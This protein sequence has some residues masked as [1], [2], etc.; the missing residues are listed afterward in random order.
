MT[1]AALNGVL[2]AAREAAENT[3][4][5]GNRFERL[6]AL[7]LVSH[8]GVSGSQRFSHVWLWDD[9]PGCDGPDTGID[10]VAEQTEE[11]GGGL[12]AIQCKFY[13]GKVS[14]QDVDSFLAASSRAEFSARIVMHTGTGI[15]HHGAQKMRRAHPVCEEFGLPEMGTWKIDWWQVAERTHAVSVG[16]PKK[17][18][19]SNMGGFARA[20]I[21]SWWLKYW[22]RW[23]GSWRRGG[24]FRKLWLIVQGLI[25]LGFFGALVAA[26]ISAFVIVV[27]FWIIGQLA[28]SK[29]RGKRKR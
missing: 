18:I 9:W 20:K 15:Q 2:A 23:F 25:V 26:T 12:C 8:D 14:T 17:N 5:L 24:F 21:R 7:A 16:S 11:F 22:M 27:A 13:K 3:T 28:K 10:L 4:D 6:S 29:K 1:L 19:H